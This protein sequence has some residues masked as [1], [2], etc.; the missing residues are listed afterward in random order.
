MLVEPRL[1]DLLH[2]VRQA[3]IRYRPGFMRYW[4]RHRRVFAAAFWVE[5]VFR[6]KRLTR[7]LAR[8]RH[9]TGFVFAQMTAMTLGR[10]A[11]GSRFLCDSANAQVCALIRGGMCA[12]NGVVLYNPL[13]QLYA[14]D[15]VSF[16]V[17]HAR[18]WASA[19]GN[20]RS[21]RGKLSMHVASSRCSSSVGLE[22]DE[23]TLTVCVVLDRRQFVAQRGA[24]AL[25]FTTLKCYN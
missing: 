20:L 3:Q 12:V 15:V 25:P 22:I 23:L 8:L 5:G 17:G 18:S 9:V 16:N 13:A 2:R 21:A 1:T 10:L 19:Q 24:A 4:R 6:Q 7:Y 11:C 14:S